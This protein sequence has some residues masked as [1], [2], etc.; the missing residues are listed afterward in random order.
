MK[1][2]SK[3]YSTFIIL[4]FIILILG[5]AGFLV[6]RTLNTTFQKYAG[7][8]LPSAI[9]AIE[10]RAE[11]ERVSEYSKLYEITGN[12]ENRWR[13]WN[14]ISGLQHELTTYLNNSRGH[15]TDSTL[16]SINS[17]IT[18]F[19]V[20]ASN[21]L[22]TDKSTNPEKYEE[23]KNLMNIQQ[24]RV[25]YTLKALI[26]KDVAN[27]KHTETILGEKTRTSLLLII[28]A[29]GLALV[30]FI[31]AVVNT[32][33]SILKPI[34]SL[35]ETA[36][37]IGDG[38]VEGKIDDFILIKDDEIGILARSFRKMV[39]HLVEVC[40]SRNELN[41]EVNEEI[42][43]KGKIIEYNEK[44]LQMKSASEPKSLEQAELLSNYSDNLLQP[45]NGI[46]G[47]VELLNQST[48]SPEKKDFFV[49]QIKNNAVSLSQL[50]EDLSDLAKIESGKFKIRKTSFPAL[51]LI[52]EV[53]KLAE[54]EK[55]KVHKKE[56][57]IISNPDTSINELYADKYRIK[58]VF[59]KLIDNAIQ[60]TEKGVIEIGYEQNKKDKRISFY[61]K[62]SGTGIPSYIRQTIFNKQKNQPNNLDK[63]GFSLAVC[64]SILNEM[65][66]E[67]WMESTEGE[68]TTVYFSIKNEKKNTSFEPITSSN[69]DWSKRTILIAD[70]EEINKVLIKECLEQTKVNL[71]YAQNG[72]EAV[73]LFS[74]TP[75][76]DLILM[77]LKMPE[78]NGYKATEIIK[79]QNKDIPII[80]NTA[81]AMLYERESCLEKG[82]DDYI[83]KPFSV[84]DLIT[85]INK[86]LK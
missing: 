23:N 41:T 44:L 37:G 39:N 70:D 31:L 28:C 78:M 29:I 2:S 21:F 65:D 25:S 30:V 24:L 73:Y 68:G 18:S 61:I 19:M 83:A 84:S 46:L 71:I 69:L 56:I 77:D 60:H 32:Y 74:K 3:L 8:I 36:K 63:V 10:M 53:T 35:T 58:Q 72:K 1:V 4:L 16:A 50:I 52:T 42:E 9:E 76:I 67:I 82:F 6:Q 48:L 81:Y 5:Y 86:H 49:S 80:A 38:N 7:K 54:T 75:N 34:K 22:R 47:F 15:V 27:T 62:D 20:Y 26:D 55:L 57:R 11:M 45:I 13:A 12:G 40:E 51:D 66:G 64:K 79:T 59:K 33:L 17:N 14:S 43:E 85:I